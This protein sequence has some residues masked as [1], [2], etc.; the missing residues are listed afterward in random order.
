MF[1]FIKFYDRLIKLPF[2]INLL[3]RDVATPPFTSFVV[4]P[5]RIL[6]KITDRRQSCSLPEDNRNT[7]NIVVYQFIIDCCNY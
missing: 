7:T 1:S 4:A 3:W 5:V 2:E 6:D